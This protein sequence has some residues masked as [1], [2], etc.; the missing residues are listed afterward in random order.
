MHTPTRLRAEIN[1][2]LEGY[3]ISFTFFF[4]AFVQALSTWLFGLHDILSLV[5]AT[6][7]CLVC[8]AMRGYLIAARRTIRH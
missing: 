5:P 1:K 8:L 2:S 7:G 6:I 4:G 3:L